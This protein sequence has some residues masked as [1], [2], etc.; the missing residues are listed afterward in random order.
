[1]LFICFAVSAIVAVVVFV[2]RG[3]VA[4]AVIVVLLRSCCCCLSLPLSL[5]PVI[6]R[7]S[8]ITNFALVMLLMHDFSDLC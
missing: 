1:M 2:V 6:T 7:I 4:I 3:V 5:Y 8:N